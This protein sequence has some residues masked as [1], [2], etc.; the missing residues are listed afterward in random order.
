[1]TVLIIPVGK[2]NIFSFFANMTLTTPKDAAII[3]SKISDI[4][5]VLYGWIRKSI[6][7]FT[8]YVL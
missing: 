5:T 3:S 7:S 2:T 1:M 6:S 8:A 4:D